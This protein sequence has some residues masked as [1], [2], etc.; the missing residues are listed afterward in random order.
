[1]REFR[2][3]LAVDPSLTC[4]GWALFSVPTGEIRCVG[5]IKGEPPSV[6]MSQRLSTFHIRIEELF[7]GFGL[8]E[9]DAL[10]CEAPTTMRDPHNAIKVEQVRGI[11]ESAARSCGALVPGR[12]NPRSVQYEVMGL[13]GKQLKRSDVKSAA[14]QTVKYLYATNLAK[15]GFSSEESDLSRQQD[16]VDALLIGRLALLRLQA[17]AQAHISVESLFE[18]PV[19]KSRRSWRVRS[20]AV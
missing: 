9:V 5:K 7:S 13:T 20:I 15:I 12:I 1:M 10:V 4:S 2:Y 19:S 14:V 3:L 17:A 11:F 8:G 6:P 18:S 16:I